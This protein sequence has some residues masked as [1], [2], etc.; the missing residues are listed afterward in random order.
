MRVR[1]GITIFLLFF[2]Q[3][4]GS[5]VVFDCLLQSILIE[6]VRGS[7][8]CLKKSN[9]ILSCSFQKW[10]SVWRHPQNNQHNTAS[11]TTQPQPTMCGPSEQS[12]ACLEQLLTGNSYWPAFYLT[13]E[14]FSS[15][16]PGWHASHKHIRMLAHRMEALALKHIYM[17]T[18][19]HTH[20]HC[21]M[22]H[23]CAH[24]QTECPHTHTH[25]HKQCNQ[26]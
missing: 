3:A 8:A 1:E 22:T 6:S 7:R 15:C 13:W 23:T 21:V 5:T 24:T 10:Y 9:T 25:T 12:P 19:V 20:K 16:L 14:D 2:M 18:N 26:S 4:F 11:I 17:H